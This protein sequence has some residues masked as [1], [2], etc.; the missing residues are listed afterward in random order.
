MTIGFLESLGS[1]GLLKSAMKHN[2][3]LTTRINQT[4]KNSVWRMIQNDSRKND[5]EVPSGDSSETRESSTL[6]EESVRSTGASGLCSD[7]RRTTEED[8]GNHGSS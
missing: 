7:D 1:C 8:S 5:T 3:T 2:K 4:R 6:S